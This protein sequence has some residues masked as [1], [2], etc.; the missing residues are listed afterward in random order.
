MNPK[1]NGKDRVTVKAAKNI[2]RIKIHEGGTSNS[3]SPSFSGL[4]KIVFHTH[5]HTHI[6]CIYS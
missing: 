1:S 6:M 3:P 2:E 4:R 5:T